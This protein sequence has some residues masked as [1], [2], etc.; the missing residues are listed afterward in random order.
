MSLGV[1][2]VNTQTW[3]KMTSLRFSFLHVT[4]TRVTI[5]IKPEKLTKSPSL[6]LKKLKKAVEPSQNLTPLSN[7]L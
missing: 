6:K 1:T 4:T 5:I 7:K 2:V 3:R